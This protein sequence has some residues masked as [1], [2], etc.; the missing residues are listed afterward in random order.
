MSI[1]LLRPTRL[2]VQNQ[3]SLRSPYGQA[4]RAA[5]YLQSPYGQAHRAAPDCLLPHRVLSSNSL[6]LTLCPVYGFRGVILR[7]STTL[8]PLSV[9]GGLA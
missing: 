8:F 7:L 9:Y 6:T 5:P 3:I 2:C 1:P 4:H